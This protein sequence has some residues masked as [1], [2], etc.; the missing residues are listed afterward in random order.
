MTVVLV[1][2]DECDA[3]VVS[4]MFDKHTCYDD[5]PYEPWMERDCFD[6]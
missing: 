5:D 1:T 4:D 3:E 2:C 6:D